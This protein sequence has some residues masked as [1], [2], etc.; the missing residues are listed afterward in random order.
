MW[1]QIVGRL[2]PGH[3]AGLEQLNQR[4]SEENKI[5]RL[6]CVNH[7]ERKD[8]VKEFSFSNHFHRLGHSQFCHFIKKIADKMSFYILITNTN[9]PERKLLTLILQER[10]LFLLKSVPYEVKKLKIL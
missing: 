5:I 2:T 3:L 4:L 1:P 6:C 8:L 10:Q 7:V 9:P